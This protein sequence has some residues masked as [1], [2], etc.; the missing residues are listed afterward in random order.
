MKSLKYNTILHA[1]TLSQPKT[2]VQKCNWQQHL[3]H[4]DINPAYSRLTENGVARDLRKLR[5]SKQ[6]K[7]FI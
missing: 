5:F 3:P 2:R 1:N 6:W 7:C 4:R